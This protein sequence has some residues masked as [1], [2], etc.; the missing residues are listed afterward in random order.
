MP[1]L[2]TIPDATIFA[3]ILRLVREGGEKAVAFSSVSR[4]TGLAAPSL[5]QRYGSLPGMVDA[6]YLWSWDQLDAL[7][8]T[9]IAGSGKDSKG[10]QTLLKSLL[11]EAATLAVL[12]SVSFRNTEMRERAARWRG[13]VEAALAARLGDA[14]TA[15]MVFAAWQGQ[16]LWEESGGKGFKLKDLS[17]K[18][19]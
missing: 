10:A 17:R 3:M 16:V 19:T 14:E 8:Q 12:L 1:R 11:P 6:A 9:T 7:A 15:A 4:K 18:L 13:Q 5:V 2:R